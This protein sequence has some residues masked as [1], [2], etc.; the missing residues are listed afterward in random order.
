MWVSHLRLHNFRTYDSFDVD[1]TPGVTTL[2]APNGHGKTNLVEALAYISHLK[3]HRVTQDLTLVR[4]SAEEAVVA[5]RIRRGPRELSLDVTIRARGINKMRVNKQEVRS[6][7]FIGLLPCVVFAPEDLGLV[8]GEPQQRRDFIDDLLVA[9]SPRFVAV[10]ADFD[11]ALRQ[12]NALL[13]EIKSSRNP[14]LESTL[15][16]WDE[17]FALAA[18]ELVMGRMKV[19]DQLSEPLQADFA[20]LARDAKEE[21]ATTSAKYVSRIDYTGVTTVREA[22]DVIVAELQVRRGGEIERGLTLVGPQRDD[23]ELTI[24]HTV[25]KGYASHGE[26]WSLALALK[27]ASWRVLDADAVGAE[28]SAVLVLDD[29]FAELDEGRRDRLAH[30]LEPAEQVLITAAVEA[31]VPAALHPTIIR[32]Q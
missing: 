27:L 9:R 8:K 13:K 10:L 26:S 4:S 1:F 3:S 12:R 23:V 17:A 5:A 19:L 18:S 15:S 32:L 24:G 16:I 14:A 20:T 29:V 22:A 6:K 2:V 30:M 21:R 28:D 11:K 31:D 7:E 25:A